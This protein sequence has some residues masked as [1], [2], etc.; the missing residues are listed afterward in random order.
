METLLKNIKSITLIIL[1]I[2]CLSCESYLE[3]DL[4]PGKFYSED[5]FDSDKTTAAAVNNLFKSLSFNGTLS[6]LNIETAAYTDE[7][8]S[9]NSRRFEQYFLDQIP[10]STS[11]PEA[12][13][14][15]YQ[16]IF[17]SNL[18][19][20]GV[21]NTTAKLN[22]KDQY[23][24]ESYFVR[25]YCLYNLTNLYGDIAIPLAPEFEANN[26]LSRAPQSEVYNQIIIDLKEAIELLP[27]SYS[28]SSGEETF[29]KSRPNKTAAKALL[30]KV[31]LYTE[32]W[33]LAS[34]LCTEVL[35]EVSNPSL[36]SL[37]QVFLADSDA[38]IWGL[39]PDISEYSWRTYVSDIYVYLD[40]YSE[41]FPIEDSFYASHGYMSN[42][43]ISAFEENDQRLS[44]WTFE[45]S[46]YGTIYHEPYKYKSRDS[47]VENLAVLRMADIYLTRAEA[48][49]MQDNYPSAI[50]DINVVRERA[51]LIAT[52]AN[53][54]K[55]SVLDA[56]LSERRFEFFNE[57]SNRF[58]DLKRLGKI[59]EVMN[60][61]V[62]IKGEDASWSSYKANWPIALDEIRANPNLKQ[63]VG[64][65]N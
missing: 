21:S 59:D 38:V 53:L 44:E 58:F 33:K 41:Y 12:Y 3:T 57:L 9:D 18:I 51:G 56:V 63:T 2:N 30:A 65:D 52:T 47:G 22:N 13:A 42:S 64:Y 32:D 36:V 29:S 25:A 6:L 60:A 48:L 45:F 14:D 19:I 24:G 46:S 35:A 1:L 62:V 17:R 55:A 31:Y 27:T 61:E 15:L 34:D 28:T 40:W 10:T 26:T 43:L 7:F 23:L 8:T 20:D 54:D 4:P 16:V 5:I 49:A 39:I 37:D 50:A 11:V